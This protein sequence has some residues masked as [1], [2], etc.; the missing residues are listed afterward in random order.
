MLKTRNDHEM[1]TPKRIIDTRGSLNVGY[2][3]L[4]IKN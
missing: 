3:S 1:L 4:L 2:R